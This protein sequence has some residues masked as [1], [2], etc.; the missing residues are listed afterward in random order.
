MSEPDYIFIEN[1]ITQQEELELVM[2][3]DK[4]PWNAITASSNSRKVQQYGYT[5]GYTDLNLS[6]APKIP[7][8]IK[9]VQTKLETLLNYKFDQVIIN[10]YHPGQ[11]IS[12]H[13]DHSQLFDDCIVSLSL[14]SEVD[15]NFTLGTLRETQ[16]LHRRSI[17]ILNGDSRYKWKHSIPARQMDGDVKRQRRISLTFRKVRK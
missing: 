3:I 8:W 15:M 7:D 1:F 16:R 12:P 4:Q 13:I 2:N 6:K 17:I 5:Y 10:E 14:L 9:P 11:G